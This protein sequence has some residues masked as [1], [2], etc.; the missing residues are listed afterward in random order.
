MSDFEPD[1]E[2]VA[3][4][5]LRASTERD[6]TRSAKPPEY[7]PPTFVAKW[8]C[9]TPGCGALVDVT[10]ESMERLA[11][12]N[13]RLRSKAEAPLDPHSIVFCADCEQ[14]NDAAQSERRR[15]EVDRMAIVIRG[16][17]SGQFPLRVTWN[18]TEHTLTEAQAYE[19]LERWGHPDVPGLKQ[20][21]AERNAT[22]GAKRT[23]KAGA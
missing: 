23:R 17:K 10:E 18:N 8:R 5:R 13:G 2:V 21:I 6:T 1:P 7:V 22:S 15:R 20:A 12:F 9:K 3:D 4:L 11:V 16:V 19:K 14:R